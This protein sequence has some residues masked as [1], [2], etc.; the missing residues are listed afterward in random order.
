MHLVIIGISKTLVDCDNI[1][2]VKLPGS[3]GE[4]QI[5]TNHAN[6]VSQLMEGEI[7]YKTQDSDEELSIKIT[8]GISVTYHN[9]VVVVI[10]K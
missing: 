6:I 1:G 8:R 4:F 2:A 3:Q 5:L 9:N 10:D 7:K